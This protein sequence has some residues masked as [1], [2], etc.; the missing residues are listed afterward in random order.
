M[1]TR[2]DILFLCAAFEYFTAYLQTYTYEVLAA[3][4]KEYINQ[5]KQIC[6]KH[7]LELEETADKF[8]DSLFSNMAEIV[9]V[10]ISNRFPEKH[11]NK[12]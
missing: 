7:N 2:D 10:R 4:E 12:R 6:K 11:I 8:L 5:C 9:R 1:T 3:N